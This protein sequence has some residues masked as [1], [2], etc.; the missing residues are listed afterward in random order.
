LARANISLLQQAAIND[1]DE[2]EVDYSPESLNTWAKRA[3]IVNAGK[4]NYRV[5]IIEKLVAEGYEVTDA[6]ADADQEQSGLINKSLQD[7]RTENY[8][9]YT[10]TIPK[11]D[12]PTD[13]ELD[14][15]INKKAKTQEERYQ[16]RKGILNKRYGIEVTPELVVKDDN[17]WYSQLQLHYYLTIGNLYLAQRDG[18]KLTQQQKQGKG[19]VFKPDLNKG[20]HSAKIKA[21]KLLDIEQ[22][23]DP[24]A[25][26][27][28]DSLTTWF[29]KVL[30]FRFEIHSILGV[31]INP[32]K[33]SPIAIAQR[34]L[35]KLGIQL[36]YKH[37]IRIKG[38]PTRIYTGCK[39]NSDDRHMVFENWLKRDFSL[40]AVT[41]N[42]NIDLLHDNFK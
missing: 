8:R 30:L 11:A 38:K 9:R 31:T 27:S 19:R 41:P 18:Q 12:M 40:F 7:T 1:F 29:H 17:G 5:E 39:I 23:L 25:E 32:D 33:D 37:Q 20:I 10:E 4:N 13:S 26:F 2:L 42:L 22:F 28:K 35:R 21:L 3:C 16:E 15:L 24:N 6:D 34:I 36:E 14:T